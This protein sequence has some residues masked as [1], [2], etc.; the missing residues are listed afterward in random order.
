MIEVLLIGTSGELHHRTQMTS[1]ELKDKKV[2][3][4][5]GKTY[6]YQYISKKRYVFKEMQL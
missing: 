2:L 4:H 3:S 5:N 1:E 6:V